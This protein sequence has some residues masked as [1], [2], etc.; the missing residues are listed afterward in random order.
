MIPFDVENIDQILEEFSSDELVN[1]S[2]DLLRIAI[3]LALQ[4]DLNISAVD[5]NKGNESFRR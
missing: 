2:D 5:F 1:L 4:D 3:E